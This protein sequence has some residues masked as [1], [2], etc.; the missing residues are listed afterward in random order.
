MTTTTPATPFQKTDP[1]KV[2]PQWEAIGVRKGFDPPGA[3]KLNLFLV[4]KPGLGKTSFIMSRPRNLVLSYEDS[5]HFVSAP[6]A[7]RIYI[8]SL[9]TQEKVFTQLEREKDSPN[10]A[11][12]CVSFDVVDMALKFY[13]QQLCHEY[14][15]D[16]RKI[17]T[18][19]EFG[20]GGK[21]M[22]LLRVAF[23]ADLEK[24]MSW[25]YSWICV[26]HIGDSTKKKADGTEYNIDRITV[27]PGVTKAICSLSSFLLGITKEVRSVR[28]EYLD[29]ILDKNN[30]QRKSPEGK[31]LAVPKVTMDRTVAH[32]LSSDTSVVQEGKSRLAG[33]ECDIKIPRLGGWQLFA[34]AYEKAAQ[35]LREKENS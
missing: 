7:H 3:H 18:I 5:A 14:S 22:S 31:L 13:D 4:S 8:D 10:R 23:Q 17:R 32:I 24:L 12:D 30:K 15:T 28:R 19:T 33:L 29:P 11:F 1:T 6:Q 20:L 26:S 25:G 35:T 27:Y 21:G 34:E 16:S 2:P 9:P